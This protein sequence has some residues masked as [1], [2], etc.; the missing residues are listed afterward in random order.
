MKKTVYVFVWSLAS[1]LTGVLAG[2]L[3]SPLKGFPSPAGGRGGGNVIDEKPPLIRR[4]AAPSPTEGRRNP[5]SCSV[6]Y[7]RALNRYLAG[8]YERPLK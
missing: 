5:L 6:G 1:V 4:F 7:F 3:F 8:D 2:G